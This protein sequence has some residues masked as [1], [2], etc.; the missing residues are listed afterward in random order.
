MFFSLYTLVI[1]YTETLLHK[2]NQ[3]IN[4]FNIIIHACVIYLILNAI[5]YFKLL[6]VYSE[7]TNVNLYT[8]HCEVYMVCYINYIIYELC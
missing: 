8:D 7:N 2:N 4:W 1:L 6:G 5:T 3:L